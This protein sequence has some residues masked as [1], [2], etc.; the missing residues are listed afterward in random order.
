MKTKQTK[1]FTKADNGKVSK[2]I[3]F[4]TGSKVEIPMEKDGTVKFFD[5]TKLIKDGQK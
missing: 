2:V 5:D 1:V 4:E 3:E